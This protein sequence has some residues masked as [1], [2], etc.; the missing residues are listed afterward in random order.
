MKSE[1]KVENY[2]DEN[3]LW[4]HKDIKCVILTTN[5]HR[6]ILGIVVNSGESTYKVGEVI[7]LKDYPKEDWEEFHGQI[8][9]TN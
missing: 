4:I 2:L 5:K 8:I 9:L 3:T 6:K 1:M 7:Y